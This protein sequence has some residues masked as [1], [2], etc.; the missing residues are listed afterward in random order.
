MLLVTLLLQS[1]YTPNL[2][3]PKAKLLPQDPPTKSMEI[4]QPS[5]TQFLQPGSITACRDTQLALKQQTIQPAK[6]EQQQD[7]TLVKS[8]A[9]S[10]Q[11][12][13]DKE[14]RMIRQSAI[15]GTSS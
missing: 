7:L 15:S 10:S 14:L 11:R 13:A 3:L 4:E 9:S 12:M 5:Q 1:C 6:T 2:D 8:Q